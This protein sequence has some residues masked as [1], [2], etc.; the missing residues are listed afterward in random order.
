MKN[1]ITGIN[2]VKLDIEYNNGQIFEFELSPLQ[3]KT[4]FTVLGIRIND[5]ENEDDAQDITCFGERTLNFF[6]KISKNPLHF[7][8]VG[9]KLINTDLEND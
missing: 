7:K 3:V 2:N 8:L 9:N 1:N 6:W 5:V 4:I